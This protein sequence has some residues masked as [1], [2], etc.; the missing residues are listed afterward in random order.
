LKN[1]NNILKGGT[2]LSD[3]AWGTELVKRGFKIGESPELLNQTDPEAVEFV[4]RS[5]VEAGADIILTNTFGGNRIVLSKH[6]LEDKH[7]E[8]NQKGVQ[9]SKSQASGK[10]LVFASVGPTGK[11]VAMGEISRDEAKAVFQKQADCL[12][13]AGAD[14]IVVETM[15]DID[16]Y[17]AAVSA[18]K[19]TGLFIV[20]CMSFD[21]GKDLQHTMMGVSVDQMVRI[22]EET[23]I[24]MV[25]ANCGVGIE[26]YIRIAENLINATRL[27]IWIKA[28]AGLPQIENGKTVYKMSPEEFSGH[29]KT[30]IQTGVRVIGGCCG[31][32]PEHI[33]ACRRA[34]DSI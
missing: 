34:M 12:K 33:Q 15:G 29:V 17:E 6:H 19:E 18:A 28:N 27:P 2:Y 13:G 9:L 23:G 31:T 25:G 5:Y 10:A 21:S 8:L 26:N 30:L 7:D 16:E 11:M 32:T 1:V 3:G 4:A 20:G 14:G 22:A 24:D